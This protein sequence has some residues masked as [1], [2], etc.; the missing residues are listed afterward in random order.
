LRSLFAQR[1]GE[2]VVGFGE[3]GILRKRLLELDLGLG[4]LVACMS[5]MPW[6]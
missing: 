4:E 1:K 6:L 2:I 3:L 5:R